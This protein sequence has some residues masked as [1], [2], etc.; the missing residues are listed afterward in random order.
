MSYLKNDLFLGRTLR[1]YGE[2]AQGELN[3]LFDLIDVGNTVIDVGAFMGTHT[4]AFARH[5]GPEGQVYAFEPHPISFGLLRLNVE[6]NDLSNVKLF[7]VA[8]SDYTGTINSH[9]ANL[10]DTDSPGSFSLLTEVDVAA[11]SSGI[12]IDVMT[13]DQ[14]DIDRCHLM[15]VDVEGME[16]NVLKGSAKTLRRFRPLVFAE[17]LSLHNGWQIV[18]FMRDNGFEAFLHNERAFNPDNFKKNASN[19][20]GD[21]RETNIVFVPTNRLSAFRER[22]K[23]FEN[24]IPLKT[25]DDLALGMLKKP[26]YK[27]EALAPTSA[28]KILGIDFFTNEPELR[29]LEASLQEKVSQIHS[30]E[31]QIHSLEYQIHSLEYQMQQIQRSI[32]MQLVNRY[33]RVVERLLRSGTRRRRYYELGLTG[34]WV[35]LNEGWRSFF[36]NMYRKVLEKLLRP[37]TRRRYYY[38]LGLT[39]I[40]VILNEGW[41]SFWHKFRQR[42]RR[43]H[44]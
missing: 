38:E 37:G 14:F 9:K 33:Q 30:L 17:C 44:D 8:L 29:Q 26:Q 7:N 12:A 6:Q 2:W 41:K 43:K 19:F 4:I 35:I 40:R 27:Y 3:L 34:I 20:L 11:E 24:L 42:Y 36:R 16:L 5:V 10:A 13:L 39:G 21:A 32:P 25:L 22:C 1:E 23:Y 28:A 18:L 31:Y 15:K